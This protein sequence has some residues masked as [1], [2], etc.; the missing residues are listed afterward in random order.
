MV[1]QGRDALL[2]NY[3]SKQI[4]YLRSTQDTG[5]YTDD[6]CGAYTTGQNRDTRFLNFMNAFPPSCNNPSGGNCD[7]VD[8]V[9]ESHDAAAACKSYAGMSRLFYD[10]F[11]GKGG[12]ATDYGARRTDGDSPYSG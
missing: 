2:A 4:S 6:G 5:D 8:Y 3:N 7:T 11:D 10:N 12:R 9:E 1:S